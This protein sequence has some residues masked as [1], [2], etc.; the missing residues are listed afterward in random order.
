MHGAASSNAAIGLVL[1][2]R[3]PTSQ[4]NYGTIG[5]KLDTAIVTIY[6]R[7]WAR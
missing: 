1:V 7:V 5:T 2:V 6:G 4:T 3:L